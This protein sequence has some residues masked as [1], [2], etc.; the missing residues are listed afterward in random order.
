MDVCDE[1][2]DVITHTPDNTLCDNGLFC[3]GSE[4]CDELLD[5]QIS[6]T[7]CAT[8]DTC[9]EGLDRCEAPGF[10]TIDADCSNNLFC[11]GVETCN[12]GT[13][14]CE[15]GIAPTDDDGISCTVERFVE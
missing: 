12:V 9:N 6:S 11:D 10:C 3:D 5:C 2:N 13:N 15:V 8:G 4:T 7:P 14:I 1:T